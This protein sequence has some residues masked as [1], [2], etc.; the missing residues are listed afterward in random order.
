MILPV[1][2]AGVWDLFLH[3]KGRMLKED[4]WERVAKDN[5]WT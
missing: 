4:V 1:V 2:S 5:I 3:L